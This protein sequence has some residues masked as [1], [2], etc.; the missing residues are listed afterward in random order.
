MKNNIYIHIFLKC[1]KTNVIVNSTTSNLD[2]N[3]GALSQIILT[4]AGTGIQKECQQLYPKGITIYDVAITSGGKLSNISDIFHIT[5]NNY[6]NDVECVLVILLF[7]M[8]GNV[9]YLSFF[10]F[11]LLFLNIH[12][13]HI[14]HFS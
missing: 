8:G 2:L 10:V 3:S 7:E 12:F 5:A 6:T 4:S 11:Q 14:F 13:L 9:F 1:L